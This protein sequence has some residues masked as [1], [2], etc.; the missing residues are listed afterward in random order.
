[1][2]FPTRLDVTK[3]QEHVRAGETS[4]VSEATQGGMHGPASCSTPFQTAT[5]N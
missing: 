1:M 3:E 4:E 2:L 5:V